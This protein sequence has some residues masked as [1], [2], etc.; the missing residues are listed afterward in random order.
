MM[1]AHRGVWRA[2]MMTAAAL[3]VAAPAL[4]AEDLA[5]KRERAFKRQIQP[6]IERF[7]SD[8]HGG[9]AAEG[10]VRLDA[11]QNAVQ[12]RRDRKTW[13]T[14]LRKTRNAEMP[15]KDAEQPSED[16]RRQ[17]A[18]ALDELLNKLDCA[19]EARP[20]R[21]TIH[22]LNRVEYRATVRDLLGVDYEPAAD[23]P[24]DDVGYGFDN[25][26]DVLSLPPILL[27][28]YLAAAEAITQQ[29]IVTGERAEGSA[30]PAT[31]RELLIARPGDG[32]SVEKAARA[33]LQP[34]A[35]RAY[36]RP[37][38][39]A[40]L[41]R[42]TGLVLG[43]TKQGA[44][45]ES[46]IQL[47]VQALLVSPHFLFRVEK[48]PEPG[49]AER[50]LDDYE[51]ASR[52]SYFLWSSMPDEELFRL[53]AK[54]RLRQGDTLR[55]Q[56]RRMLASPKSQALVDN[57]A[58]QWLELRKFGEVQ[59]SKRDFPAFDERLRASMQR[60]T[61]LF[62]EHVVREDRSILDL[63]NADY[64][65]VNGQLAEHYE[66]PGVRGE[67]FVRVS[68]RATPRRGLL[69]QGSVLTV[70]SNPTRTSPVKRGKWILEN[71]LGEPPPPPP[72]NVPELDEGEQA[73]LSGTLRQRFEQ[74]RKDPACASC[75]ERM[76]ALGF[77]LENFNAIGAWRDRD[78]PGL[79]DASG[80]LPGGEQFD[81]PRELTQLLAEGKRD[82]FVR[83]LTE[84][85]LT[86]ALGRG[87]EYYDV[88][89]VDAIVAGSAKEE[90]R[91]S[92][93]V[94]GIV[95]SDPFLKREGLPNDS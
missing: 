34:L 25:I 9:G 46:G 90:Y 20:G 59:I 40:E 61:L 21:V 52:L 76:D 79:I 64:T 91:F 82:Q 83:C 4:A 75:H 60:E 44:S 49:Q 38:T 92:A 72:P 53:A 26:A 89:A 28:K 50:R 2:A 54:G 62:F 58:A 43:T 86:Y 80:R 48:D 30:L 27:E 39:P 14:A 5:A 31:H 78:G 69:T 33:I 24:A 3:F 45:F 12:L 84:K 16:E 36:R 93:L 81:G 88:C 18:E 73:V 56:V 94:Q 42:L 15:P 87:L 68:L 17:L 71:L 47:A 77:A 37:V 57:F 8:C 35:T 55:R 41:R 70:T 32:V 66:L 29:A 95:A 22:R 10:E 7:C 67:Q 63:L 13:L 11:A 65:F 74:H 1:P 6:A 19:T 23:F 85:L 51:L